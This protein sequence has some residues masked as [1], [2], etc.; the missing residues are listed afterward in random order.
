MKSR[1][2]MTLL[3]LVALLVV[4]ASSAS[5]KVVVNE[6]GKVTELMAAWFDYEGETW[7]EGYAAAYTMNRQ[8]DI[9]YWNYTGTSTEE[10]CYL[11]TY[12]YASGPGTLT[13]AKKYE[14]GFA[15]GSLEAWTESYVWCPGDGE[16]GENGEFEA[17]NGEGEAFTIDLEL[18]FT[19]TSALMREKS[20]GSFKI[21]G[22]INENSSFSSEYRYGNT[23]VTVDGETSRAEYSQLGA[24]TYRYHYNGK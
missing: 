13:V 11:E 16:N 4:P 24:F 2:S 18:D 3:L 15:T 21:P 17:A 5:A 20:S 10:G 19:A 22:E 7:T 8:T 9:V 12:T 6:S 14:T 1:T 23:D